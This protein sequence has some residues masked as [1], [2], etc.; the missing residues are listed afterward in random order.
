MRGHVAHVLELLVLLG[1]KELAVAVE[2]GEGGDAFGDG[3]L[4]FGSDGDVVV[5]LADVYVDEDKV[6]CEQI[7]VGLLMEVDVEDLAVAAPVATE[8][9]DD[10][11]MLLAG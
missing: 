9:E 5:H 4:I 11:L 7:G 8:V 10:A 1:V 3:D 6:I 2:D